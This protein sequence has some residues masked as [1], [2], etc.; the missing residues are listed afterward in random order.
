MPAEAAHP[1]ALDLSRRPHDPLLILPSRVCLHVPRYEADRELMQQVRQAANQEQIKALL[2]QL[3]D[4]GKLQQLAWQQE[5][6]VTGPAQHAGAQAGEAQQQEQQR[7]ASRKQAAPRRH[8]AAVPA[9]SAAAAAVAAAASGAAAAAAAPGSSLPDS[10]GA[11]AQDVHGREG[12]TQGAQDADGGLQESGRQAEKNQDQDKYQPTFQMAS[13]DGNRGTKP[14]FLPFCASAQQVHACCWLP[15]VGPSS[16][17]VLH[18]DPRLTIDSATCSQ[19]HGFQPAVAT[20]IKAVPRHNLLQAAALRDIG[21]LWRGLKGLEKG[22]VPMPFHFPK[23][24]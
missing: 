17:R 14:V 3:R 24:R 11:A 6:G 9:P 23:A 10:R 13:R 18:C 4:T 22:V 1:L 16:S 8:M 7:R 5:D 12:Q 19:Q 20:H 2:A 21:L 15:R